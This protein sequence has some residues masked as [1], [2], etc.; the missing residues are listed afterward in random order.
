MYY[1]AV[2]FLSVWGFAVFRFF[3]VLFVCLPPSPREILN[4]LSWFLVKILIGKTC[5][6]SSDRPQGSDQ[7]ISCVL[8]VMLT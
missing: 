7:P 1:K 3:V 5:S 2:W 4:D 6:N 8:E